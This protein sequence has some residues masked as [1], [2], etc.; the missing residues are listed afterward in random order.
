MNDIDGFM[1]HIWGYMMI[2]SVYMHL[3]SVYTTS[4]VVYIV[5]MRHCLVVCR[6]IGG[7]DSM[8]PK[9]VVSELFDIDYVRANEPQLVQDT[10]FSERFP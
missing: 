1:R 7:A 4:S 10:A 6:T 5:Y 8:D 2:F 3:Y 9:Q